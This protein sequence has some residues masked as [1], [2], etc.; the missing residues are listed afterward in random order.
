MRPGN[1]SVSQLRS[2]CGRCASWLGGC[3]YRMSLVIA[4]PEST[5]QWFVFAVERLVDA[6]W[7]LAAVAV[8]FV[9]RAEVARAVRNLI[10]GIRDRG[11]ELAAGTGGVRFVVERPRLNEQE[12]AAADERAV[13]AALEV[14]EADQRKDLEH[15]LEILRQEQASIRA[16]EIAKESALAGSSDSPDGR[17]LRIIERARALEATTDGE[18]SL[19]SAS[20]PAHYEVPGP[21]NDSV[22][23]STVVTSRLHAALFEQ[24][25]LTKYESES[26]RPSEDFGDWVRAAERLRDTDG[27]DVP[28]PPFQQWKFERLKSS[29][30]LFVRSL[31]DGRTP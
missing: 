25:Y 5:S 6:A 2:V 14:A 10:Q 27:P 7:P 31:T 24:A 29:T 20:Y 13:V 9:F 26:D 12:K 15:L 11:G 28:V 22:T 1:A 30:E 4:D 17:M 18:R 21:A 8:A 19:L 23:F 3:R 16:T